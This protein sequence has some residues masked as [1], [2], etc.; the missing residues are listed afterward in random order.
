MEQVVV[1]GVAADTAQVKL[2]LRD[3]PDGPGMAALIFGSLSK[4]SIVV[5]VIVQD[6]PSNGLLTVSFTVGKVDHLKAKQVLDRLREHPKFEAM[7]VIEEAA[8]AKVSIVGVGM[9]HHPGV[10]AKMFQI[11][12]DAGINITLITTSEIK[13]SCLIAESMVK[14]AVESLHRG[15]E[16][17]KVE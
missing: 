16:L 11:L 3:V 8:L 5:D 17:Q 7:K 2:T 12:A 14:K 9:Q 15:F 1:A 13:V 10:A 4:A 6:I